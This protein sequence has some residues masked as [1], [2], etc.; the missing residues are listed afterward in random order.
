VTARPNPFV[1]GGRGFGY[2][3][4]RHAVYTPMR[5]RKRYPVSN[6]LREPFR[7]SRGSGNPVNDSVLLDSRLRGNDGEIIPSVLAARQR[8]AGGRAES[9]IKHARL[10]V[11]LWER[12][13]PRRVAKRPLLPRARKSVVLERAFATRVAPT[14]EGGRPEAER[15]L[16]QGR[17]AGL[18]VGP[19]GC[20]RHVPT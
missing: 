3:H 5:A 2:R 11:P 14:G 20:S 18:R 13:K 1:A 16:L 6:C 8:A 4:P 15:N 9:P 10:T 7:R 19:C 17:L 12:R